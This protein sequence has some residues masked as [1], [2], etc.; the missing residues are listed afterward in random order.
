MERTNQ[1]AEFS[2]G[3][4]ANDGNN[5]SECQSEQTMEIT[6]QNAAFSEGR[7]KQWNGPIKMQYL[8][9]GKS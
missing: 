2:K 7:S 4:G 6:N 8:A 1:N 5:Q 3:V 9:R